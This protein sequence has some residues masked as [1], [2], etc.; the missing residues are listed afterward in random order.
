MV[1]AYNFY[2]GGYLPKVS[3]K[4]NVHNKHELKT[5]YKNILSLNNA[6][7]LVMVKLSNDTQS[8][9]LKVKELS[10]ELG[11]V[12]ED[13]LEGRQA[14]VPDHLGKMTDIFNDLLSRSDRYGEKTRK[15]SRPGGELRNLVEKNAGEL[16]EA[17][18]SIDEK[19]FLTSPTEEE[20]K[21]PQNFMEQLADK[22]EHMSMN[23]MEYVEQ[24][25]YSYAHLYRND[26]GTAYESSLYSGMLFNS[27]C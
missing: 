20:A 27:Y 22:C 11:E 14:D 3:P 7:P 10:M 5:K 23:P 6:I 21:V 24:K 4:T 9:A 1:E 8:Y 18:F 12:A 15:P 17:G 13:A 25:V 2:L 16:I 19:G 26:I